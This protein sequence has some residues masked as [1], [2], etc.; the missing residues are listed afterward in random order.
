MPNTNQKRGFKNNDTL[1]QSDEGVYANTL[2]V[3]NINS[4]VESQPHTRPRTSV[5]T[6][7]GVDSGG[8]STAV[9]SNKFHTHRQRKII[10]QSINQRHDSIGD[11]ESN[12][13]NSSH[14]LN[15]ILRPLT[16]YAIRIKKAGEGS[17][18]QRIQFSMQNKAAGRAK[19]TIRNRSIKE[20]FLIAYENQSETQ[21]HMRNTG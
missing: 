4:T 20:P 21:V 12:D 7:D 15:K 9:V 17:N 2:T 19:S 18:R 6:R 8:P 1:N 14:D 13:N 16:G 5:R 3:S 10:K 11:T